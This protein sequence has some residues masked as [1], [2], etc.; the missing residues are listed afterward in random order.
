MTATLIVAL[1]G[2]FGSVLVVIV[3]KYWERTAAT[4]QANRERK[5]PI[6]EGILKATGPFMAAYLEDKE[7]PTNPELTQR[8][9]TW[10]STDVLVSYLLFRVECANPTDQKKLVELFSDMVLAVRE[11]LGYKKPRA[12]NDD[13]K[14]AIGSF[15]L[16]DSAPS[17][18][19]A[20]IERGNTEKQ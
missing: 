3:T 15:I 19:L 8:I 11:D 5:I 17:E 14:N 10:A 13:L 16:T 12:M 20:R 7:I 6:Y 18:T 4:A 9:A 1:I 2:T